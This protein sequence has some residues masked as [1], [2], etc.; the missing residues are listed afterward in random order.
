MRA[1]TA[2]RVRDFASRLVEHAVVKRLEAN[3]DILS[4]HVQLPMR[5][6]QK[7]RA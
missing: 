3:T 6:S 2:G 7:S 5:K 1:G 4:F